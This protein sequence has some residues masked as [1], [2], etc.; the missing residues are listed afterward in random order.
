MKRKMK[1]FYFPFNLFV[2]FLSVRLHLNILSTLSTLPQSASIPAMARHHLNLHNSRIIIPVTPS[3]RNEAHNSVENEWRDTLNIWLAHVESHNSGVGGHIQFS[4][5]KR[6]LPEWMMGIVKGW[7]VLA[8][9][10]FWWSSWSQFYSN[11]CYSLNSTVGMGDWETI[12]T[13]DAVAVRECG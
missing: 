6:Q 4:F 2:I 9:H 8:E 3:H 5:K 13:L 10:P 11:I 12:P 1:V 7:A